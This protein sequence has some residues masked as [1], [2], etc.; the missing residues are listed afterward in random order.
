M[1]LRPAYGSALWNGLYERVGRTAPHHCFQAVVFIFIKSYDIILEMVYK[2]YSELLNEKRVWYKAVRKSYCPILN[3][4]ITFNAKGFH[5]LLFD[6]LGH[7]RSRK[8]RMYKLELLPLAIPVLKTATSIYEYEP[9]KFSKS[10]NKNVEYWILKEVVGKQKN[11]RYGCVTT[12][13]NRTDYILQHLEK[14][15]ARNPDNKKTVAMTVCL[16][17]PLSAYEIHLAEQSLRFMDAEELYTQIRR[18]ATFCIAQYT[19]HL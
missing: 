19:P 15:R 4:N 8:E 18:C 11:S 1:T 10:L 5:H 3:E 12:H 14:E 16:L 13:R 6:G 2:K 9:P 7:P 17:R